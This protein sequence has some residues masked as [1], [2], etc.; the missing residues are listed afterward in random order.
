MGISVETKTPAVPSCPRCRRT[1]SADLGLL[2]RSCGTAL[3]L[4]VIGYRRNR[5]GAWEEITGLDFTG[6]LPLPTPPQPRRGWS[7]IYRWALLA[8]L[9]TLPGGVL[10]G[11]SWELQQEVARQEAEAEAYRAQ[12]VGVIRPHLEA[13]AQRV[14]EGRLVVHG[15][16]NL[17]DGTVLEARVRR[18]ETLLARDYPIVV[19]AGEYRSAELAN[20]GRAFRR[21]EYTVELVAQFGP[22][23]QPAT[24][25]NIVG[26][27]GKKLAGPLVES[28][29]EDPASKQVTF[30]GRI[31]L[32]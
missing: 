16:T 4:P 25:H 7:P 28:T 24:V 19:S 21:G 18:G 14:A 30:Q 15:R 3:E 1:Q 32:R 13:T 17:P 23:A 20:R 10:W 8:V 29:E 6:A 31:S 2:C 5:A 22:T 9:S 12:G 27:G 26:P 11:W